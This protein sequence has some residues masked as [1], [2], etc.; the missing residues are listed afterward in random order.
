MSKKPVDVAKLVAEG[1]GVSKLRS[2]GVSPAEI[3]AAGFTIEQMHEHLGIHRLIEAGFNLTDFQ[4]ASFP[5]KELLQHYSLEEILRPN[6]RAYPLTELMTCV[7]PT[8]IRNVA[9]YSATEVI[10]LENVSAS[11]LKQFGYTQ[12]EINEALSTLP[13]PVYGPPEPGPLQPSH[14][15]SMEVGQTWEKERTEGTSTLKVTYARISQAEAESLLQNPHPQ[16]RKKS[17]YDYDGSGKNCPRCGRLFVL[18]EK[19]TSSDGYCGIERG[20]WVCDDASCG[21]QKS[22]SYEGYG[23]IF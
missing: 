11:D 22:E 14:A 19:Y 7:L 5:V 13:P 21:M 2:C 20:L 18:L 6:N 3:R 9:H 15:A 16:N 4:A 1:Y 8:Q 17:S 10:Q 12:E 23:S